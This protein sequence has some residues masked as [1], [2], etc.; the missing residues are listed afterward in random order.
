MNATEETTAKRKCILFVERCSV[1]CVFEYPRNTGKIRDLTYKCNVKISANLS[2]N[3]NDEQFSFYV[4]FH[5]LTI[6]LTAKEHL[7]ALVTIV[8]R[9]R[10]RSQLRATDDLNRGRQSRVSDT[11]RKKMSRFIQTRALSPDERYVSRDNA[12]RTRGKDSQRQ[13]RWHSS[14]RRG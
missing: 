9:Q 11:R 6:H 5:V 8:Q 4:I 3:R 7:R 10:R 2:N 12:C 14:A 13:R 1:F